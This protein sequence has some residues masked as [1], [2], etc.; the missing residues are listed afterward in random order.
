ME[1]DLFFPIIQ[2]QGKGICW[3]PSLWY[4]KFLQVSPSFPRG[5]PLTNWR[6]YGA[7]HLSCRHPECSGLQLRSLVNIH[8]EPGVTLTPSLLLLGHLPPDPGTPA[9]CVSWSH[10]CPPWFWMWLNCGNSCALNHFA[11]CQFGSL[12]TFL[13]ISMINSVC[14]RLFLLLWARS[15]S[16]HDTIPYLPIVLLWK[17][18]KRQKSWFNCAMNTHL[19][20]SR[21]QDSLASSLISPSLYHLPIHLTFFVHCKGNFWYQ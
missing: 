5:L 11:Q 17:L 13:N 6:G 19:L 12:L 21:F 4:P 10:M 3:A 7:G 9:F 8:W 15:S 14:L 18:S 1:S 20:K 16:W 2:L